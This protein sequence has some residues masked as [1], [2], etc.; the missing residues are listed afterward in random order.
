MKKG[1]MM[2]F[3]GTNLIMPAITEKFGRQEPQSLVGIGFAGFNGKKRG[4]FD[5]RRME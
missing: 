3:A 4:I 5:N 1:K 2:G